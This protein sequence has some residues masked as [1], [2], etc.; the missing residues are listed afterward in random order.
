MSTAP[1]LKSRDKPMD[2]ASLDMS[3]HKALEGKEV[4]FY[5]FPLYTVENNG[6]ALG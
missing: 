1:L 4:L 3:F 6:S 2:V 5:W